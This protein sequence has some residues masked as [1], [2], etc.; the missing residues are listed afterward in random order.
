MPDIPVINPLLVAPYTG[1]PDLSIDIDET[2][3]HAVERLIYAYSY[4]WDSRNAEAT[5]DLFA[6]DAEMIFFIGGAAEP[7]ITTQGRQVILEGMVARTGLLRKWR[8]ETRHL[9]MNNTF[10]PIEDDLIQVTSTAVIFWQ[11]LPDHPQPVAVQTGYYRSWCSRSV[12]GWRFQR[13][14][15]HLSGLTHPRQLFGKPSDA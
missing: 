9:M 4:N 5:A 1:D 15:T 7:S 14:E 11:Q 12:G 13:R 8:V 10:G 3:R 2:D 6:E